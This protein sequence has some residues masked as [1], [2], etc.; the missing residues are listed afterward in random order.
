MKSYVFS[1][2]DE[3]ESLEVLPTWLSSTA[4]RMKV[5]EERLA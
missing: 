5:E 2:G 4:G 1:L 3:A